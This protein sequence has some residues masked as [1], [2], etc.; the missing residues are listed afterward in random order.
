MTNYFVFKQNSTELT[1]DSDLEELSFE[2][3]AR[4]SLPICCIIKGN[5]A[6]QPNIFII[7]SSEKLEKGE[8]II[9]IG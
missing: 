7:E 6:T 3:W 1:S 8:R 2:N 5:I 9:K 4:V